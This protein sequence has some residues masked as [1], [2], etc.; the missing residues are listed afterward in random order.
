MAHGPSRT[1]SAGARM[2]TI[3]VDSIEAVRDRV[4][5]AVDRRVGLRVVGRG[6]WLDAGRPVAATEA[7][8]TRDLSGITEYVPGDLTLTA[9]GGTTL[10]E[11]REATAAHGQW[12]AL[13]PHGSDEG[14]VGATIATAS[15]G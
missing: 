8:A 12:L 10:G 14:T 2:T 4:R 5:D 1:A 6:T 9:R 11:I 3:A 15:A 7:L 13:D